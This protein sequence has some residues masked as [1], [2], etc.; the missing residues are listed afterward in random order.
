MVVL[1]LEVEVGLI[2]EDILEEVALVLAVGLSF[3]DAELVLTE[4]ELGW[5]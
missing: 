1:V 3:E 5:Y 4:E 2:D